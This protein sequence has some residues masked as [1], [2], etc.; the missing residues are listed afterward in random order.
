[1]N[2]NVYKPQTPKQ[3]TSVLFLL[4]ILIIRFSV[5]IFNFRLA[6]YLPNRK[7]SRL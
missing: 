2:T 5:L 6:V 7:S 3:E 4:S 1:M